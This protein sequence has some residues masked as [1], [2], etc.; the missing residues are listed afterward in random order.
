MPQ[1]LVKFILSI[2]VSFLIGWWAY[3]RSGSPEYQIDIQIQD[4]YF[5]PIF[6][7]LLILTSCIRSWRLGQIFHFSYSQFRKTFKVLFF[8]ISFSFLLGGIGFLL[9]LILLRQGIGA[10]YV[11][12]L[13]FISME[14]FFDLIVAFIV[15]FFLFSIPHLENPMITGIHNYRVFILATFMLALVWFYFY[16]G[17]AFRIFLTTIRRIFKIIPLPSRYYYFC[18]RQIFYLYK[19]LDSLPPKIIFL[20]I[21]QTVM[22]FIL[23]GVFYYFGFKVLGIEIGWDQAFFLYAV[24]L[25][26][27]LV[28]IFPSG[29]GLFQVAMVFVIGGGDIFYVSLIIHFFLIIAHLLIVTLGLYQFFDSFFLTV[30]PI[31]SILNISDKKS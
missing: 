13:G 8:S 28:P 15:F 22:I 26:A 6:F 9:R 21:T 10:R 19:G 7:S 17:K 30:K 3:L 29:I 11:V 20:F 24:I 23:E 31:K 12:S 25:L 16:K 18:K 4:W 14:K 1:G 2:I 5:L 27:L